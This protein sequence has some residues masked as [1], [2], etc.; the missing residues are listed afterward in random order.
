MLEACKCQL[1]AL[2]GDMGRARAV[3]VQQQA[4]DQGADLLSCTAQV[5]VSLITPAEQHHYVS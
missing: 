3:V 5:S 4:L 1:L 2:R